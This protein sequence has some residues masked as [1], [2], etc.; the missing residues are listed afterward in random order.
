MRKPKRWVV[1]NNELL[2]LM[3]PPK[4]RNVVTSKR[5]YL[6]GV[7]MELERRRV[8][9]V[10]PTNIERSL[11]LAASAYFSHC[12]L[13]PAHLQIALRSAIGTFAKANNH[14]TS[15]KLARK[16]LDFTHDPKIASQVRRNSGQSTHGINASRSTCRPVSGSP[17]EI[18][19]H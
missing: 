3:S 7:S 1:A 12:K 2:L 8:A 10:E 19:I 16:L 5:E 9:E 18:E 17:P 14:A 6:L 4:W 15:A 11:E 13:Q